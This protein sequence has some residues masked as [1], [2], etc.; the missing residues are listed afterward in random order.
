MNLTFSMTLWR[1]IFSIIHRFG[2]NLRVVSMNAAFQDPMPA[3]VLGTTWRSGGL[4]SRRIVR[5][6]SG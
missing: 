4:K 1:V 6:R 3:L 5:I 2:G